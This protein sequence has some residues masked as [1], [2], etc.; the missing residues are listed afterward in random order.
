MTDIAPEAS[1]APSIDIAPPSAT[2]NIAPSVTNV[3]VTQGNGASPLPPKSAGVAYLLWF[4]LG[5]F[6]VHRFYIGKIGTGILFLLTGGI[7]G[8]GWIIDVFT[9]AGQVRVVNA[10]RAVGIK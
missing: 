9:L 10:R 4:F 3:Y 7:L 8:I 6:G 2:A 1:A 5:F